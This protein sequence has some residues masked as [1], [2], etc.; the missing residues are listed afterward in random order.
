MPTRVCTVKGQDNRG[1]PLRV[2]VEAG[3]VLEAAAR[4]MEEIRRAEG[5]PSELEI[6][7]HVPKQDWKVS[8]DQLLK[9]AS[10]RGD[11]DNIGLQAIKRELQEFLKKI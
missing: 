8:P 4:G 2:H 10:Q 9:W 11:H 6:T 1:H 5:K 7:Q 3:S